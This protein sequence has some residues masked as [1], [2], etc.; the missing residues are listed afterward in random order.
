M[1]CLR[2][3]ACFDLRALAVGSVWPGSADCVACRVPARQPGNFGVRI[4][5]LREVSGPPLREH[6]R[7]QMKV[8]KAKG[9]NATP[10]GSFFALR[11]PGP[12]GHLGTP[13]KSQATAHSTMPRFAL[14][15]GP[16]DPRGRG[17]ARPAPTS[18]L[19]TRCV[20]LF[21]SGPPDRG[22]AACRTS[23]RCCI[24]G[25]CFGDFHLA[26]QMKVTRPPGRNPAGIAV[27]PDPLERLT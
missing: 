5:S 16:A 23:E 6:L 26:L 20:A 1:S 7:P 12:A 18:A 22:S 10:Y 17:F 15:V 24:E 8:T 27:N 19:Q 25:L 11:T 9:L 13:L 21:P 2:S 3:A 14:A 4:T